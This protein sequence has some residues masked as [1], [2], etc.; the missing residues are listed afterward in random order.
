MIDTRKIMDDKMENRMTLHRKFSSHT[1]S[2]K[3]DS[4]Q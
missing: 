4:G 1:L 2:E 3:C